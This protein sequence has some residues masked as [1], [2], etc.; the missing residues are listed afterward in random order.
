V[1]GYFCKTGELVFANAGHPPAL[2][3][4]ASQ[5]T[6]DWLRERTPPAVAAVVGAPLGLIPGTDYD[7][8]AVR[9]A[10]GDL[11]IL[12]TDGVT[13]CTNEAANE[14]GYEGLLEL[15]RNLPVETSMATGHA[16]LA[17]VEA[18]RGS[19]PCLDDQSVVVLQRSGAQCLELVG[20]GEPQSEMHN[21][22]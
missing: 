22:I 20:P 1:L 13:E 21:Q 5:K 11:L 10:D 4:R 6:W 15:V 7:Q 2:W 16:L 19:A 8:T 9:L 18:F 17:A 3:Y 12:Y 14:L